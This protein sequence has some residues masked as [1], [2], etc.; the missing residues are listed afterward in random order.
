M[1]EKSFDEIKST[2]HQCKLKK[3]T[4]KA[5]CSLCYGDHSLTAGVYCYKCLSKK[6]NLDIHQI[7][8]NDWICP[9]CNEICNCSNCIKN[10][11][12]LPLKKR[13]TFNYTKYY[14]GIYT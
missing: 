3:N 2:C 6:Y 4:L 10:I 14:Q 8:K 1:S 5:R 9:K 11:K 12:K 7:N 13:K